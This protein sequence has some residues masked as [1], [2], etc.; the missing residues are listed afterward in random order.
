LFTIVV[1]STAA[2]INSIAV[3]SP[4]IDRGLLL[5]SECIILVLLDINL[6]FSPEFAFVWII[7][8]CYGTTK[9]LKSVENRFL[10]AIP[11]YVYTNQTR[12]QSD[13]SIKER[14]AVSK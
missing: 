4:V 8:N 11:K 1:K 12:E 2:E 5:F 7:I 6:I 14:E 3:T 13:G 10:L 9:L